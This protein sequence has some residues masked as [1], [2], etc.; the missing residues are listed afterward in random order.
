MAQRDEIVTIITGMPPP[1]TGLSRVGDENLEIPIGSQISLVASIAP[2]GMYILPEGWSIHWSSNSA[3]ATVSTSGTTHNRITGVTLGS[4]VISAQLHNGTELYGDAV[5]FNVTVTPPTGLTPSIINRE[6]RVGGRIELQVGILP[7]IS[8]PNLPPGW[9]IRWWSNSAN[10]TV[11]ASGIFSAASTVT[12]VALGSATISAQLHNGTALY[13]NVVTFNVEV[14]QIPTFTQDW[15][16]LVIFDGTSWVDINLTASGTLMRSCTSIYLRDRLGR[17][18]RVADI[19]SDQLYKTY[20]AFRGMDD[21]TFVNMHPV[22]GRP[23]DITVMFTCWETNV[24]ED[25]YEV[26]TWVEYT[27]FQVNIDCVSES[28][29]LAVGCCCFPFAYLSCGPMPF[30]RGGGL[31][32]NMQGFDSTQGHFRIYSDII[33]CDD[34]DM[35]LIIY[36]DGTEEIDDILETLD[37]TWDVLQSQYGS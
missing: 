19:I 16:V 26:P 31:Y 29:W 11:E 36:V 17:F 6:V 4:A 24:C 10:A 34:C 33:C 20:F 30:S 2:A 8:F 7:G 32:D 27:T 23:I 9:S 5:T 14:T 15:D 21:M 1:P 12:G 3:N 35:P 18:H 22:S 28:P 25:G 37:R 13:G